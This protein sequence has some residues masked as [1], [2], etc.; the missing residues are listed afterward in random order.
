MKKFLVLVLFF[1]VSTT[2]AYSQQGVWDLFKQAVHNTLSSDETAQT[3]NNSI[4]KDAQTIKVSPV[5]VS[6]YTPD[7]LATMA[8]NAYKFTANDG[9]VFKLTIV[10][11]QFY[12]NID[13]NASM[14]DFNAKGI[15]L[16][17]VK[18][19]KI[20]YSWTDNCTGSVAVKS[21]TAKQKPFNITCYKGTLDKE[22]NSIATSIEYDVTIT[23]T[24]PNNRNVGTAIIT[25]LDA[26]FG[27]PM[28]QVG[29][30]VVE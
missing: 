7:A 21:N 9:Q 10:V 25:V 2:A 13:P 16:K 24:L 8:P 1:L 6:K 22:T 18:D 5:D 12:E 27:K 3:S 11:G 15:S 20:N 17:N 19:T 30:L 28:S 4:K 14:Q 29:T 26:R 23:G